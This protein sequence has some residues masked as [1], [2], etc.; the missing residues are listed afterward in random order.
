MA[1][2]RTLTKQESKSALKRL[3]KF[4]VRA[5]LGCLYAFLKHLQVVTV[6]YSPWQKGG[7]CVRKM[8]PLIDRCQLKCV[9]VI[10]NFF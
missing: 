1:Y 7:A 3:A 4:P 5:F 10:K 6:V 2:S 9:I 8:M